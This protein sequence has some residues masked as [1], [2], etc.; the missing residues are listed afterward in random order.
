MDIEN[1]RRKVYAYLKN[2]PRGKIATYKGI[3][4][5]LSMHPRA[6]AAALKMNKDPLGTP[7]YKV[8]HADGRLGGYSCEGGVKQKGKLLR[9]DG[10]VIEKGKV[11]EK[12]IL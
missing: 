8:A 9:K 1:N 10:V 5:A 7:C 4:S 2:I 12:H 3:A 11:D 6:V